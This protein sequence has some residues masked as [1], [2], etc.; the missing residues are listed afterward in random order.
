MIEYGKREKVK[1]F[2]HRGDQ[3][4]SGNK[5]VHMTKRKKK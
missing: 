5:K 1:R 3:G 4:D 2:L